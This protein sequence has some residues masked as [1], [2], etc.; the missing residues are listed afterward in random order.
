MAAL[1]RSIGTLVVMVSAAVGAQEAGP[2]PEAGSRAAL[3]ERFLARTDPPPI[4]YRALRRLEARSERF[5]VHGWMEVAT[6]LSGE[7]QFSWTSLAEGGSSYIRNKVLRRAL[8]AEQQAVVRND[9]AGSALSKSNYVFDDRLDASYG[10]VPAGLARLGITPRRKDTVLIDGHVW[11]AE[12]DGDLLQ[13][14]GRLS[15]SPSFWTRNVDVVRRYAR[16][17]GLRVPVEMTSVA[18]VRVAGRSSFR[19]TY[20]YETINGAPV[21][22]TE[23]SGSV[24]RR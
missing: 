20:R 18:D 10:D 7:R 19:M 5:D 11:L 14:D 13:V 1:V 23:S 15:K 16:V 6:E 4:T 12:R 17:G 21:P 2:V 3:L 8:E 24:A 22:P 9:P